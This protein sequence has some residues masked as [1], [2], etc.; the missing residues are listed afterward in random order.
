MLAFPEDYPESLKD[1]AECIHCRLSAAQST[2]DLQALAL[3]ITEAIRKTFSGCVLYIPVGYGLT[4]RQRN[5]AIR[6]A[7]N[8]R[9]HARLAKEFGMTARTI[10]KIV[11]QTKKQ[12]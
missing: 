4:R 8:G 2:T 6:R 10:Y 3:D 5:A 12:P 7:F 9:N 11:A 1:M